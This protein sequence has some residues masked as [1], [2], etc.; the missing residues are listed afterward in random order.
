[1]SSD[2]LTLAAAKVER[3][4]DLAMQGGVMTSERR[5]KKK[6]MRLRNARGK[7]RTLKSFCTN[8]TQ[9]LGF[10]FSITELE[11]GLCD[12]CCDRHVQSMA[13]TCRPRSRLPFLCDSRSMVGCHGE[14]KS[15]RANTKRDRRTNSSSLSIAVNSTGSDLGRVLQGTRS[16]ADLAPVTPARGGG[17]RLT[18]SSFACPFP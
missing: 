10:S 18:R 8:K 3:G 12:L 5:K 17:Q 15:G 7:E 16:T 2:T 4:N 6:R 14:V 9:H 13:E 11:R 1:V